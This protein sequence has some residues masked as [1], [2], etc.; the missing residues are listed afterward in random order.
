MSIPGASAGFL[1]GFTERLIM[2]LTDAK[3]FNQRRVAAES[4]SSQLSAGGGGGGGGVWGW[5]L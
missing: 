2:G 3:R 5:G 4:I 1:D